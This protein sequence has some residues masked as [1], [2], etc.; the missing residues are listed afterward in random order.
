MDRMKSE[1]LRKARR[2]KSEQFRKSRNNFFHRGYEICRKSE[3][4]MLVLIERKGKYYRFLTSDS[5][6]HLSERDIVS[7]MLNHPPLRD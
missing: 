3:A 5:L 4:K 6:L 1:Q 7:R 2:N